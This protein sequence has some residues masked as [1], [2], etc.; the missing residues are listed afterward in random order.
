MKI[1][2]LIKK[3]DEYAKLKKAYQWLDGL[4]MGNE[5]SRPFTK[6]QDI[7]NNDDL[8]VLFE[9]QIPNLIRETMKTIKYKMEEMEI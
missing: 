4:R 2:D 3:Q 8:C 7:Q 6:D 1:Q 5:L 9:E